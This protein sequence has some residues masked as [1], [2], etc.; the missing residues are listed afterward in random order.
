MYQLKGWTN[1]QVGFYTGVYDILALAEKKKIMAKTV[2]GR[3]SEICQNT[4]SRFDTSLD[5]FQMS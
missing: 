1:T 3:V 4:I 5:Y 2:L